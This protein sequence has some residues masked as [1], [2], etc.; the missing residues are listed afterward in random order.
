MMY[1]DGTRF[2]AKCGKGPVYRRT[3]GAP[4]WLAGGLAVLLL[5]GAGA[6]Y[7]GI[8][9][10]LRTILN[11]P[12][13][14][15]V[16]LDAVP[17]DINGWAGQELA[18]PAV[19]KD[20]METNFADDFISRR[21]TNTAKGLWADIY[22]VYCSSQPAGILG[23][24]PRVCFPAHGWIHDQTEA[25]EIVSA[26]RRPIKCLIH[27]FHNASTY[28]QVVV[29]SFYVLNG[30]ITLTE[31]DFAGFFGRRPNLSGDPARYVAQVQVSSVLE[32]CVRLAASDLVDTL[33]TFLPDREGR[34]RA[35][36]LVEGPAGEKRTV[37]DD[38]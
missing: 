31:R 37:Q 38:H 27:R 4:L 8:A 7:R 2:E 36:D 10:G 13:E 11:T 35:V 1:A 24:Q 34:V 23:H 12:I 18:I 14:L 15:P 25:S 9:S 32:N 3:R 22:V 29:L 30:Q 21:Y 19:T 20:Y 17:M 5:I 28:Q 26:D 33:L 6:A 16:S